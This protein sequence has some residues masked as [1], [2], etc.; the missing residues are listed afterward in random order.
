M[1]KKKLQVT[2]ITPEEAVLDAAA[3]SVVI[4]AHDGELGALPGR[5]PLMC[6]L[7]IGVLRYSNEGRSEKLFID[8]GFAQI[9]D[10][11]VTVL[12]PRAVPAARITPQ[13]IADADR[14]ATGSAADGGALRTPTERAAAA[15]RAQ[16]MR[17]L[18]ARER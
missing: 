15:R 12:S 17:S 6:E 14:D 11:R 8:G 16:A 3:D 1:A 2:V 18:T 10:D 13:M 4:P 7:G 9:V 5:A